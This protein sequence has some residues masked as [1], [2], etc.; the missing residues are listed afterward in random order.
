MIRPY[1]LS[2]EQMREAVQ[3]YEDGWSAQQIA[4]RYSRSKAAVQNC[5]RYMG[6]TF[7]GAEEGRKAARSSTY[8]AWR[9]EQRSKRPATAM[10]QVTA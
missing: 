9:A 6:V 10:S 5:L 8:R 7:R 3:L 4:N 2:P 1:A